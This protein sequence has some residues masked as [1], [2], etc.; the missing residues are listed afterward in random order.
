[1][2]PHKVAPMPTRGVSVNL[3]SSVSRSKSSEVH[4][5][6][7]QTTMTWVILTWMWESPPSMCGTAN[8]YPTVISSLTLLAKTTTGS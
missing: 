2:R 3:I 4:P 7:I 1:M 8:T 5:P 6:M